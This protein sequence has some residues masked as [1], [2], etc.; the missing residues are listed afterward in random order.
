LERVAPVA[1]PA[2]GET[3][4]AGNTTP[5]VQEVG[6]APG[7]MW[8]PEY[9]RQVEALV[10]AYQVIGD[11]T[12]LEEAQQEGLGIWTHL[13]VSDKLPLYFAPAPQGKAN[14]RAASVAVDQSMPPCWAWAVAGS[15]LSPLR[16]TRKKP[17]CA[18][19]RRRFPPR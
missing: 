9:S 2:E 16:M 18:A 12:F 4:T 7:A 5:A 17:P 3:E 11:K 10:A 14:L 13:L 8:I 6:K 15:A 1:P 19:S